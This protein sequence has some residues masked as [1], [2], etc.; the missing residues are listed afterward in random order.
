MSGS[1][2]GVAFEDLYTE[3]APGLARYVERRVVDDVVDDLVQDAF[4]RAMRLADQYTGDA[5]GVRAWLT[6]HAACA[7]GDYLWSAR[8]QKRAAHA[9]QRERETLPRPA[10]DVTDGALAEALARLPEDQRRCVQLRLL[11]GLSISTVAQLL[12]VNPGTVSR[13]QARALAQLRANLQVCRPVE[14]VA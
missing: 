10:E 3:H 9:V 5:A 2:A 13:R 6:G 14:A 12:G 11:D 8:S 7:V 1:L 4:L